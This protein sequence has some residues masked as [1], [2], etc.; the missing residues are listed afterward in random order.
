MRIERGGEKKS[1]TQSTKKGNSVWG[2]GCKM[3]G[4]MKQAH[5]SGSSFT[6]LKCIKKSHAEVLMSCRN[7]QMSPVFL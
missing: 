4:E 3:Q 1:N 2:V 7:V 6:A 5:N